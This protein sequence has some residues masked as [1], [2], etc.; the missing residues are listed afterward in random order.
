VV[1]LVI[2]N[3]TVVDGSGGP[4]R[5]GDV[6]IDGGRIVAIGA[7]EGAG[8]REIDATGKVVSPGFVDVHTH[9]DAQVFWD[10]SLTPSSLHGV[11]TV[12]AGNCGFSIAPLPPDPAEQAYLRRML[13]RV[14]AMPL[15]SLEVGVPWDWTTFG[16]YLDRLD[17]NVGVNVGVMAGHSTIRRCVLGPDAVRRESTVDELALMQRLLLESMEAGALGLSSSRTRAHNDAEGRPVPS[18]HASREELVALAG[19]VGRAEGT[20]IQWNPT[21]AH[22]FTAGDVELMSEMT[23]AARRLLNW[24]VLGVSSA[25]RSHAYDMLAVDDAV[26]GRGGRIV[27]VAGVGGG[28]G[29]R[30]GLASGFVFDVFPGWDEVMTLP[31]AEKLAALRDPA[32]RA[33]LKEQAARDDNQMKT[34]AN[35]PNLMV[36]E[37]FSSENEAYVGKTF[38]E[39]GAEQGRDP[40][41]VMWDVA[42][43]D[44]LL[45]RFGPRRIAPSDDDWQARAE[46]WQDERV[47]VGASDAGAHIDMIAG[48]DYPSRILA[49]L[50]RARAA[51]SIEEAVHLLTE[52]PAQLY[53]LRQRGRLE[54]GWQADVVVLDLP[55]VGPGRVETRHDLPA[56]AGRLYGAATGIEHVVV[57]GV[58]VVRDGALTGGLGGV[59][60]RSG[61][62]T[63]SVPA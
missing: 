56:G 32:L 46:V 51:L 49:E 8:D 55:T 16:E 7:W 1:D 29:A 48:F 27:A 31:A 34:F 18:R 19:V 37:V 36:Y 9:Y 33:H 14:E 23:L 2:R 35:W 3:G 38:G 63:T 41:D 5:R 10:P 57:N 52:V 24:N 15:E 59:V 30:L 42:F 11:T 50:V 43:A 40:Y 22:E 47:V 12:I 45:T 17:G 25:S 58:S 53:G 62:D 21:V 60:L 4:A 54:V 61:R 39:I 6:A 20:V 13:A 44:R 26:R 28:V